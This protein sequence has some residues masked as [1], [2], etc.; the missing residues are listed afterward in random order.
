MNFPTAVF[1]R[2]N[3]LYG[4]CVAWKTVHQPL[5]SFIFQLKVLYLKKKN[6]CKVPGE[7]NRVR[8]G[9]VD[10]VLSIC[11]SEYLQ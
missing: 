7:D 11:S 4:G 3:T 8:T 10:A 5:R 9:N 6:V 2:E 1:F